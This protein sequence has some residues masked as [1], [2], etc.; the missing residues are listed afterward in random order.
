MNDNEKTEIFVT[1][2]AGYVGSHS[3]LEL[4]KNG[5]SVVAVDNFSNSKPGKDQTMPESLKRVQCLA[6]KE[7]TFYEVDLLNKDSLKQIFQKHTFSCVVHFAALKAVGESCRVPLDYYRNNVGGSVNLLEVMQEFNVKRI[8]FSSSATVY[9][10]PLY[11]PID[12]THPVGSTCTNPYGRTKYFIE[13]ILKDV[14]KSEKGWSVILLRY[15]NP[16]GAHESGIIGEDP[17]GVPNNLMP[18]I[19]QVAVGRLKELM[20]FGNDYD[21]V[22]GTGVRDFIH[23]MDL[24]E[25]HVSAVK[26]ILTA[27]FKGCTAYNLGTG[28]G[29]SVLEVIKAFEDACSVKIPY[30][31]VDRRDGDVDSIYAD[32]SLAEK[33][34]GWKSKRSLKQMCEDTWRWQSKNP[35][36]FRT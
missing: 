13:E 33:C 1:G 10:V 9:G 16:V 18:Y 2:G 12:E 17:H 24:A 19:S 28:K 25:G 26:E 30:I 15:F 3:I 14:S 32:V 31:I 21:T 6:G 11:L 29:Y 36:G 5:Y 23:V 22:D 35:I 20:V 27:E 34:L 7:L 8:V 4:L